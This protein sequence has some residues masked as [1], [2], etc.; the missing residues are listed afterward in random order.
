LLGSVL[1]GFSLEAVALIHST[2]WDTRRVA[3]VLF[4]SFRFARQRKQDNNNNDNSS[5]THTHNI[6]GDI[7]KRE[8]KRQREMNA[9]GT[10]K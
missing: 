3:L 10:L 5:H 8:K 1:F 4:C 6:P 9:Q 7:R 2:A